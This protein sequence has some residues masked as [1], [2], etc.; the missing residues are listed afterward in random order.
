MKP[1]LMLAALLLLNGCATTT[2]VA[3]SRSKT[4]DEAPTEASAVAALQ[5][6]TGNVHL[7]LKMRGERLP[8]GEY[9]LFIHRAA[10]EAAYIQP[11]VVKSITPGPFVTQHTGCNTATGDYPIALSS[12][13]YDPIGHRLSFDAPDQYSGSYVLE[14]V[15]VQ[16]ESQ[17]CT[18]CLAATPLTA[19]VDIVTAPFLFLWELFALSQADWRH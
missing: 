16:S 2:L 8:Q 14:G 4:F 10:L 9:S 5:Q 1:I 3:A 7:C 18:V 19:A 17:G 12:V 13:I 11:Q 6:N 15:K